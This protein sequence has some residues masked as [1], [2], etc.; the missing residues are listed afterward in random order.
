[1][2][3][4]ILLGLFL[5][6]ILLQWFAHQA[7]VPQERKTA[8]WLMPAFDNTVLFYKNKKTLRIF[9]T[10]EISESNRMVKEFQNEFRIDRI[11]I[12]ELKNTYVIE[13][14]T[15]F[16]IDS[17]WV[18]NFDFKKQRNLHVLTK[19]TR[20]NLEAMLLQNEIDQI[21]VDGSS[22]PS[23]KTRWKKDLRPIQYLFLR[24]SARRAV[25]TFLENEGHR[26][27]GIFQNRLDLEKP[28]NH[29][30]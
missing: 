1:M 3:K 18:E 29:L 20:V 25:L 17:L 2:K 15:L 7:K 19:N 10:Q 13:G 23:V 11:Q 24:S 9:C 16:F 4:R 12:E 22:Y 30:A 6:I 8:V 27:L 14:K 5:G 28:Y 21:I 26:F